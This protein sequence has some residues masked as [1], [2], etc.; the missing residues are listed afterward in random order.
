MPLLVFML[1]FSLGPAAAGQPP[2]PRFKDLPPEFQRYLDENP[3]LGDGGGILLSEGEDW[4]SLGLG[5]WARKAG[6]SDYSH[7]RIAEQNALA[8]LAEALKGIVYSGEDMG[9]RAYSPGGQ[10]A[11]A[12]V[13]LAR[14]EAAGVIAGS[15]E[16][17]RWLSGAGET[18]CL[19]RAVFS[20][21]HPLA[22]LRR[23]FAALEIDLED[24]WRGEFLSRPF[25]KNGGV[26]VAAAGGRVYLLVVGTAPVKDGSGTAKIQARRVAE[27]QARAQL[28]AFYDGVRVRTEKTVLAGYA[29][30][31]AEADGGKEEVVE[32]L[33]SRTATQIKGVA[34][35]MRSVGGWL[36]ADGGGLDLAYV[37]DVE[38]L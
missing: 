5:V 19:L 13:S 38:D 23:E 1:F 20:P 12:I 15:R 28:L 9:V 3:L 14:R 7:W 24:A 4:L 6:Q 18:Y 10:S 32:K 8:A 26:D 25:L 35:R 22:R 30:A 27:I 29:A 37:V 34:G 11:A 17:G 16:L 33:R 2:P 21:G 31:K 36:S